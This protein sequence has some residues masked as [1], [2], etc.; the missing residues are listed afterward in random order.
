M[1]NFYEYFYDMVKFVK[2][3]V[4]NNFVANRDVSLGIWTLGPT[5]LY[6]KKH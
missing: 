5:E 3:V 2:F 1:V 6:V 4:T